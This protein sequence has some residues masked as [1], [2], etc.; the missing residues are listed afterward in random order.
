MVGNVTIATNMAGRG[1]D[2]KL[3]PG[4]VWGNCRVP[5]AEKF[6]EL[7]VAMQEL[8][9]PGSNKCCI[10][11]PEYNAATNCA[12][13]FKPKIDPDFPARGRDKCTERV[14][15]GLHI[16][17]TAAPRGA[18]HRQPVAGPVGRQGDPVR[19]GFSFPFATT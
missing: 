3:G 17:G 5:E 4:V 14:P 10:H 15:C 1:T 7:G 6:A 16:V 13:C 12:H 18:A 11:C 9:P 8:F 2:I 19:A